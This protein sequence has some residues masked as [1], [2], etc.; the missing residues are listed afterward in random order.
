MPWITP[1]AL[2]K[3]TTR[4][5]NEKIGR[6]DPS[7]IQCNEDVSMDYTTFVNILGKEKETF[8]MLRGHESHPHCHDTVLLHVVMLQVWTHP[9][10]F[11]VFSE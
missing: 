6:Q 10:M 3:N 8:D 5:T 11:R 2:V 1:N 9:I 4:P 7:T